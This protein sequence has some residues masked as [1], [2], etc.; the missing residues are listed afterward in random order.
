MDDRRRVIEL[1]F[2][3]PIV[4][5]EQLASE[6]Y[7]DNTNNLVASGAVQDRTLRLQL[8]DATS[9]QR[10]TYLKESSWNPQNLLRGANGMAAL[11]FCNVLISPPDEDPR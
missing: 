10:I 1:E 2:D 4:W 9:A 3:Q 11:T 5:Q 6:F 8:K 7:F